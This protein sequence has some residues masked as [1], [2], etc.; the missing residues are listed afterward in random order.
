MPDQASW[1]R[2]NGVASQRE[3][4]SLPAGNIEETPQ[5]VVLR[6]HPDPVRLNRLVPALAAIA[7]AIVTGA[8]ETPAALPADRGRTASLQA[9]LDSPWLD[10][11]F[12]P[13]LASVSCPVERGPVKEGS[14]ADRYK[15]LTT[16]TKV[17]VAY[18]RGRA[19]PSSYPRNNRVTST[20]L[21]T[22]Q[23]TAYLTQY[24]QEADGDFHLV[25]KD[26]SGRSVIAE[27]PYGTCV[28]TASRWNSKIGS[29]RYT[30]AHR[31]SVTTSWHYVHRLVDVRGIGFIDTLH[32][33]TGVAPNGVELH[34]VIY[35]YFR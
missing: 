24:K 11:P 15:V 2:A 6:C 27:I 4:G 10:L 20:E 32:G 14:D 33:Q 12:N 9:L 25:L 31:Y 16:V 35:V 22:Y 7:I 26:S 19:K 17:S 18:L 34:P 23:V 5:S 13:Q 30:F 28:P 8:A 29:A 21:H 3:P 1:S